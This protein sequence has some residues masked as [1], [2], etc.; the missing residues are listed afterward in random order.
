MK[1]IILAAGKGTRL[2]QDGIMLPKVL[3]RANDKPLLGYVLDSIDFIDNNDITI[4]AGYMKE[5]VM[6]EFSGRN[7]AVQDDGGYGTGYA[8]MCGCRT[9]GIESF[10]GDVIILQGDVPLIKK[11][12]I[13]KMYEMHKTEKNALTLLSCVTDQKL[14]FGRI[15]RG[16]RGVTAIVEEKVATPEQKAIKELNVGL[17]ILDAKK[18]MSALNRITKNE[19][20]GEYYFTD[21]I[22]ILCSDGEKVN[23]YIT[24]DETEM[25]GV[26]TPEDLKAVEEILK[27][28]N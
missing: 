21:A 11:S 26:N 23:A 9:A 5:A 3:R 19:V 24:D 10:D 17:Y 1:A 8:V 16:E 15:I 28:R 13:E 12:T 14:P 2:A 4:V 22:G 7:F 6:E 20:S 18:L 25:W 27:S